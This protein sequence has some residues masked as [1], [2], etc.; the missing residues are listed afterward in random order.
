MYLVCSTTVEAGTL[1]KQNKDS[2]KVFIC[3]CAIYK[4]HKLQIDA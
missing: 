1:Y 2:K 4:K 3:H